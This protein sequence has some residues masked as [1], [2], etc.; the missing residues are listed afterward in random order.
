MVYFLKFAP[1]IKEN[2]VKIPNIRTSKN[3]VIILKI[4]QLDLTMP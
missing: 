4:D 2:I 1:V 3:I